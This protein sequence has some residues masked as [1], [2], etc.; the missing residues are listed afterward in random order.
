MSLPQPHVSKGQL[1]APPGPHMTLNCCSP[2]GEDKKHGFSDQIQKK[3]LLA[4]PSALLLDLS[5]ASFY[6]ASR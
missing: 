2:H 3:K 1:S 5:T 6:L 4:C